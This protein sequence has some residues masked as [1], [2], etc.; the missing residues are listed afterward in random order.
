MKKL[1]LKDITNA[2]SRSEMR[3]V[4]GAGCGNGN[5]RWTPSRVCASNCEEIVGGGAVCKYCCD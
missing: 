2:M 3:A 4:K 5:C 1:N